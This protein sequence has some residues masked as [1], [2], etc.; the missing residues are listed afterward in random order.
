V[1]SEATRPGGI[2]PTRSGGHRKPSL[3]CLILG[4]IIAVIAVFSIWANRQ[5]LNT[6]NW[7]RTSDKILADKKVEERLSAFL[8]EQ[9]YANVDVKAEIE[10]QLPSQVKALA[11]PAAGGLEA[12]APKAAERLLA[13]P[14][15]QAIW[16]DANRAAHETLLK[17]LNGG[18]GAISTEGGAVSLDLTQVIEEMAGRLGVGEGLAEKIPAEAGTL[19]ILKAE[20]ISTAQDIA[21]LI[22]TLP[23]VLTLL[24]IV[25]YALAIWLAGPRRR[26]A[27][28]AAGIGFIVAGA[29]ALLLRSV[30]GHAIV[31]SLV[32]VE[33]N[34]PAV[35]A[36]WSI[37]TSLLATV[38]WSA[39]AF[40]VLLFLGAWL[41]GPT[42]WATRARREA[43][44]YLRDQPA[45]AA[46]AAFLLWL[47]LL[48]LVPIAAFGKP[49]GILLF[50]ILFAAGAWLL[51]KQ[52]EREFPSSG[53]FA[54]PAAPTGESGGNAGP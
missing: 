4:T 26:E 15:V 33:A 27:L 34:K 24:V 38:A 30:A 21:K 2:T 19:T 39:F 31:N 1:A 17:L 9:L 29:V 28:R 8:A 18:S 37:A 10:K 22:R 51:W 12:L 11:G 45:A 41:A 46:I 6:D 5:A 47:A 36:V 35:E 52:T 48:A 54:A 53:K 32:K 50:A 42:K 13:S 40:G 20:Q 14:H 3:A 43:A 16:S 23:V 7:V 25:L 49:L 44:P